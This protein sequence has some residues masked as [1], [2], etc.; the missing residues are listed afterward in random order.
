M[1]M[2]LAM[3][4]SPA[5]PSPKKHTVMHLI[6]SVGGGGAE[7]F[8]RLLV[9]HLQDSQWHNVILAIKV[10]PHQALADQLRSYGAEVHDL[11]E[12]AL[13][14]P[15]VWGAVRRFIQSRQPDVIQTWMHHADFIGA[16]AARSVGM[17]N[18]VWGVRASEMHRNAGDSV[19]KST[20]FRWASGIASR[21]LPQAILANSNAS[22]ASHA[23]MGY[24]RSKMQWI[25]NGV[26]SQRFRPD[27]ADGL[28]YRRELG[29]SADAR[30][31]G[32]V[33]RFNSAKDLETLFTAAELLHRTNP[34]VHFLMV[35]GQIAELYEDAARAFAKIT[36]PA[37]FHFI[38]FNSMTERAYRAMDLFTLTSRTE[39]FP[40]VVL[41]A[42]ATA[43]PCVT[44]NAGDCGPMLHDLGRVVP[45]GDTTRLAAAWAESLAMPES[46]REALALCSRERA[47]QSYS[48]GRAAASFVEVY[49]SLVKNPS[50]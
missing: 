29:L 44:T 50:R 27:A 16:V 22:I 2:A 13:L 24:P 7:N 12:S 26:N 4:Q 15:R 14:Q 43:V 36:R 32:F 25:P 1:T 5:L 41:E 45:I 21:I 20:L 11:N 28:N 40:N 17:K 38:S 47:V 8:M 39:G 33:G 19:L 49:D 23:R 10:H 35:G 48:M 3:P 30:V 42:M 9:E 46:K 18:V 34:D 31:I 37:Q 6:P